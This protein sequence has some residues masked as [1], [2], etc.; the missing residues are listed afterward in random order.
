ML[1][2]YV[3]SKMELHLSL[4]QTSCNGGS[5]S[6]KRG[7][8][9]QRKGQAGPKFLKELKALEYT[10]YVDMVC[11]RRYPR[12]RMEPTKETYVKLQISRNLYISRPPQVLT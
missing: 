2:G 12:P 5:T 9:R 8:R 10:C 11:Q 1:L 7:E 3:K 4:E 6:A